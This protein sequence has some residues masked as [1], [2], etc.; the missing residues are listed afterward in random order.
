[1]GRPL[2][3]TRSVRLALCASTALGLCAG[4]LPARADAA[5]G[6]KYGITD[7]AWL[8]SG[9]GSLESRLARLDSLGVKVV[10]FTL[11][12]NRLATSRPAA[13]T[14]PEDTAYDWSS[15]DPVLEGLHA[16]G[17]TVVL[18]L[19]GTPS[20]ANGG[21]PANYAP[22]SGTTF[23][24][25]AT[26]AALRYSWVKR[27]LI[28]NEP[29]Q[30]RW[31]RP[32]TAAVYTTRLLNPAYAAIHTAISGAQV[33]GGGTAPRGSAGG[34]SPVA[35][36]SGMRA[37]HAKLDAYA[38]N[39]YPLDP[40]RE[41]PLRGGCAK[42]TTITMSTINRLVSLVVKDFPR[43]RIWLSEYGYQSNPPDR[44]LGVSFALQARYVGEGAYA[45]YKTARVDL[46]IHFLYR[47]EPDIARF[48][49]G[50]ITLGGKAKPAYAAFQLPFAETARS[51][52]RTAFW[53]QLRAPG[54]A[55]TGVI[56]SRVGATWRTV[57]TV[58]AGAGRFF[59]WMGTLP[60]GS[61][62]RLRSGSLV[63]APVLIT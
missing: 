26:A 39:P 40:K 35:W 48:Q 41:S 12:W 14:D 42:C 13:P 4:L 49:S 47:D 22:S 15:V 54:T 18:Q 17:M 38:H 30:S 62:V 27:W 8:Q 45:A 63:G 34:V 58:R 50:L 11:N 46:L 3:V 57:A 56:E 24:S 43:A 25:F 37:A 55:A 59:R 33:A 1:M 7:D 16:H 29:N 19:N 9:P 23:A 44:V 53:G 5:A 31:L 36:L 32:T 20:W 61:L 10:R 2:R 28:W 6:V 52:T 51:G 60:K 21:R